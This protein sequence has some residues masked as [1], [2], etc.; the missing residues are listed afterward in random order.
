MH[1]HH[2]IIVLLVYTYGY[3]NTTNC[4]TGKTNMAGCQY[5]QSQGGVRE[6]TE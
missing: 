1:M 6:G 4:S 2:T 3:D 5:L